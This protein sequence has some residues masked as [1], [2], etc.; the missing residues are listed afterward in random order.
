MNKTLRIRTRLV[1]LFTIILTV[2]VCTT[3]YIFTV[4]KNNEYI[5]LLMFLTLLFAGLT[6]GNI[7]VLLILVRN[8]KN[9]KSV[10]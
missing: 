10:D 2:L 6:A 9:N 8:K 3:F 7:M 1:A 5:S 4:N